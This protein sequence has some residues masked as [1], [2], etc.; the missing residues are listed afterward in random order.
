MLSPRLGFHFLYSRSLKSIEYRISPYLDI[1]FFEIA[2]G[3][4]LFFFYTIHKFNLNL[5]PLWFQKCLISAQ[6]VTV[7]VTDR[8]K[9]G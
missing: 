4:N 1:E 6:I 2:R 9:P 5:A 7:V 3:A 8:P